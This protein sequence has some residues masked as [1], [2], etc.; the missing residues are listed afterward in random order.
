MEEGGGDWGLYFIVCFQKPSFGNRVFDDPNIEQTRLMNTMNV[1]GTAAG[2]STSG[3]ANFAAPPVVEKESMSVTSAHCALNNVEESEKK[4]E[5]L[6]EGISVME[7]E[8]TVEDPLETIYALL[9]DVDLQAAVQEVCIRFTLT[10]FFPFLSIL[11]TRTGIG[12]DH[13]GGNGRIVRKVRSFWLFFH[14]NS[15]LY[16]QDP[17]DGIRV[18]RTRDGHLLQGLRDDQEDGGCGFAA[19]VCPLVGRLG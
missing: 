9:P 10:H 8:K 17:S 18:D 1:D 13:S 2:N 19:R 15:C 4:T 6:V 14:S 7:I 12:P 11:G 3:A 5:Q 16:R